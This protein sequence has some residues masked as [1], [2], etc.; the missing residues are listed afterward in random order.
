LRKNA[1]IFTQSVWGYVCK[2]KC[3]LWR[4]LGYIGIVQQEDTQEEYT[5]EERIRNRK[6]R[7]KKLE[8]AHRKM[9]RNR[10]MK[11]ATGRNRNIKTGRATRKVCVQEEKYVY[12]KN[13]LL[14]KQENIVHVR[15]CCERECCAYVS[16][17]CGVYICSVQ[18]M[19]LELCVYS[20]L[21]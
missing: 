19:L 15:V 1:K 14:A 11:C 21:A 13:F 2:C 18:C 8:E 12:R 17:L 9:M 20:L 16:F 3:F 4:F 7:K 5:Q 6:M 10:K